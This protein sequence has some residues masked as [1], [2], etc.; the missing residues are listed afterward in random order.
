MAELVLL[1][2]IW[3]AS[4]LL[5]RLAIDD[6][7]APVVVV[8]RTALAAGVLLLAIHIQGGETRRALS[9][10]RR[11]PGVAFLLGSVAIAAPF[12]LITYGEIVV[13]TGLTAVLISSSPIFVALMAPTLDRTEVLAPIRWLGLVMGLAGVGL[14]VGVDLVQST[15]EILGALAMI[16]A[17]VLYAASG[18]IV[19]R[20]Y[21]GVPPLVTS[22]ASVGTAAVLVTPL[23]AVDRPTEAPGALAILAVVLLGVFGTAFAFVLFYRL[24][25]EIGVGRASLVAYLIPGFALAYGATLLDEE[26]TGAVIAGLVLVVAGTVLAARPAP[27]TASQGQG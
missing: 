26:I 20:G 8:G 2:A 5:I 9:D 22:L 1:S 18:F 3:G 12:L 21:H 17:A 16:G 4:Y 23:L 25:G 13:P 27:L 14:L 7:P 10:L 24:M 19:K 6:L 11:R 15:K